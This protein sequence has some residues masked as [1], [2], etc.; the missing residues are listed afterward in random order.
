MNSAKLFETL[1]CGTP[2]T[3]IDDWTNSSASV[4]YLNA[5]RMIVDAGY[6]GVTIEYLGT[7]E[8]MHIGI[9]LTNLATPEGRLVVAL[10]QGASA[11]HSIA[12][13]KAVATLQRVYREVGLPLPVNRRG[14]YE[15]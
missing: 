6:R 14:Q 3:N 2:I 10:E 15:Q 1:G 13:E 8:G 5:V 4:A 11:G 7:V 9:V 12:P